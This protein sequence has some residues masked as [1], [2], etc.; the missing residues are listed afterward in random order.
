MSKI[1]EL[2]KDLCDKSTC[3]HKCPDTD[4]CI[5]EEEAELLING[6]KTIPKIR[7]NPNWREN[8]N[9]CCY[10]CG[11][12]R[13]V[14]Y[15]VDLPNIY[16]ERVLTV[17]ACNRCALLLINENKSNNSDFKSNNFDVKS[18]EELFKQALVEGLNRRFD[19]EIEEAKKIEQIEEMAYEMTQYKSKMCERIEHNKCL[20]KFHTHA[21]IN[22]NYCK[23]AEHLITEKNYQKQREAEWKRIGGDLG[24]VEMECSVCG[25][26]DVFDDDNEPHKFCPECGA[27][28]K[29]G[30]LI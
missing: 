18:N 21:F 29:G 13:S 8:K 10:F 12:T 17:D 4:K 6:N 11:E 28:M 22:C 16:G 2:A 25:Y 14:K 24:Y 23:L 1:K 9:R 15:L 27:K 26:T 7:P 30:A 5:V 3:H 19:R 20:L